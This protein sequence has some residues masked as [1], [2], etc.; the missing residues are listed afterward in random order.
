MRLKLFTC[1]LI[2]LIL[3]ALA[4]T[5]IMEIVRYRMSETAF[6]QLQ[7]YL[8]K[9]ANNPIFLRATNTD[10]WVFGGW[11]R[12]GT[13]GTNIEVDIVATHFMQ[14]IISGR[15]VPLD[16][17]QWL[18]IRPAVSNAYKAWTNKLTFVAEIMT[19]VVADTN[20]PASILDQ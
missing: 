8:E 5:G 12:Q 1:F 17:R 19:N 16:W 9:Q 2:G 7:G 3:P 10:G 11:T 14:S 15:D 13:N 6:T 18:A 4:D 20:L